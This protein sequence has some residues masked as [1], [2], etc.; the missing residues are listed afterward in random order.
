[1]V[2]DRT[3]S[4]DKTEIIDDISIVRLYWR[5]RFL[6]IPILTIK[7]FGE[8]GK[9]LR[10]FNPDI[11]YER[12]R[13][14]GGIGTILGKLKGKRTILEVNDPTVDAPIIEGRIS[15][16]TAL[17]AK[18]WERLV[19]MFADK[20]VTH[21]PV[22]VRRAN[23]KKV[24]IITNGVDTELFNPKKYKKDKFEG[25]FVV[26]FLGTFAEWQGVQTII[27]CAKSMEE[28]KNILFVFIGGKQKNTINTKFMG[29]VSYDK[30]PEYIA[31]SDVCVY[32]PDNEKYLPMKKLGFYFS[33]LKLFEY[34]SMAKPVIVSDVGNL[35]KLVKDY[36]IPPNNPELL[37][38]TILKLYK[39][40]K[41]REKIGKNNR[42]LCE[43]KYEW[44]NIAK[45]ILG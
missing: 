43:K 2:C 26:L 27:D 15:G 10:K 31:N 8:A 13:I 21:H 16:L 30:I 44:T 6:K 17:F 33:P 3:I 22:M 35:K 42:K 14:F 38:K 1:M 12:Y 5:F 37:K 18:L 11:V 24:K 32:V 36:R 9:Q 4:Q 23:R 41:L 34:M 29:K 7:S 45:R 20:I 40:K 39:N 25:K 28:Y 19:F